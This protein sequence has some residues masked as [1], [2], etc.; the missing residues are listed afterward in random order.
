MRRLM[1]QLNRHLPMCLLVGSILIGLCAALLFM[2]EEMEHLYRYV[3]FPGKMTEIGEE[4]LYAV[5]PAGLSATTISVQQGIR[6][7][8]DGT[9]YHDGDAIDCS[10]WDDE[11]VDLAV[12]QRG[13][14]F[15]YHGS[16]HFYC[17]DGLPTVNLSTQE[18]G[19]DQICAERGVEIQAECTVADEY[20]NADAMAEGAL[21][22]H[23][24]TTWNA[25]KRSFQLEV[26][27]P[28]GMLDMAAARK[29][30]LVSN[31]EDASSLLNLYAYQLQ[32]EME[33]PYAPECR[34]VNLYINGEYQGMYL[35][36]RKIDT[37]DVPMVEL[38]GQLTY[39]EAD[40]GMTTTHRYMRLRNPSR[41]SEQEIRE[42]E[43]EIETAEQTLYD[44]ASEAYTA[45]YDLTSWAQQYLLQELMV[46]GDTELNSEYFR[47]I[48]GVLYAGPG[49]DYDRSLHAVAEDFD[50]D[51]NSLHVLGLKDETDAEVKDFYGRLWLPELYR[52]ASFREA[53]DS[54]YTETF[55]DAA[56]RMLE[57]LPS[58]VDTMAKSAVMDARCWRDGDDEGSVF[59]V[60][61]DRVERWLTAR[62]A[63]MDSYI[64][65]EEEFDQEITVME[66]GRYNVIYCTPKD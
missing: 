18:H 30:I 39:L 55:S 62:L 19:L 13:N 40:Q 25:D 46:N 1:A 26:E 5:I 12:W 60:A 49:W 16:V 58:W 47:L 43:A 2:W 11:T 56:H 23:G 22:V 42:M 10:Q 63:F 64:G 21:K 54:Y 38:C 36:V 51:T 8:I 45:Y 4:E 7:R 29:W 9:E 65:H 44:E 35:L 24:N 33:V 66:D 50:I 37:G 14:P 32:Q 48:D 27:E 28:V 17:L 3:S 61:V 34:L 15:S 6:V 20:G 41:A 31:Y 57:E 53:L 59:Y 52:H